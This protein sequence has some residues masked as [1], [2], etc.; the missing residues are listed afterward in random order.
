MHV[1]GDP[2]NL[3]SGIGTGISV[4]NYGFGMLTL[5]AALLNGKAVKLGP[6]KISLLIS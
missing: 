6:S 1:T 4:I 2:G 5:S 3:L